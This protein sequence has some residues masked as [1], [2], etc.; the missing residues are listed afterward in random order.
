MDLSELIREC[1]RGCQDDQSYLE[2][3]EEDTMMELASILEEAS[4]KS[5]RDLVVAIRR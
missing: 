1:I 4:I 2:K 5:N 3:S